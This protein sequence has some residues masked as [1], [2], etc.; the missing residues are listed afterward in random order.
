[1]KKCTNKSCNY[2]YFDDNECGYKLAQRE[3]VSLGYPKC[4]LVN[5][6][7]NEVKI[8]PILIIIL[9]IVVVISLI[10]FIL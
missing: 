4:E 8:F 5:E 9:L 1:M 3:G 2:H 6:T 7:E 10:L